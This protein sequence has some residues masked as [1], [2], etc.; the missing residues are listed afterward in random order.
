MSAES[1]LSVSRFGVGERTCV[2]TI[3][4]PKAGQLASCVVEWVPDVPDRLSP[5]EMGEYRA[6]RDRVLAALARELGIT[7]AVVEI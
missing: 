2:M 1:P 3:P 6:G 5:S 4:R 7:A